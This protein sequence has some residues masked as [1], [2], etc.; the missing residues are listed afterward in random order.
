M[1]KVSY[2]DFLNACDALLA[3]ALVNAGEAADELR[4]QLETDTAGA[5]D[6]QARRNAYKAQAQQASRDLDG[7]IASARVVYSRLRHMLIAL[8]GLRAEKLVEFGIQPLR[9]VPKTKVKEEPLPPPLEMN[10]LPVEGQSPTQ[11]AHSQT[12]STR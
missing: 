11:A 7:F 2:G 12:E 8:F 5:K 10:K 6:A 3:A 9:P 4:L 1:A